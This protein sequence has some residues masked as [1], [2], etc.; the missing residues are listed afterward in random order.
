[1]RSIFSADLPD[2]T[3]TLSLPAC[4]PPMKLD[5]F[6]T[7][8]ELASE[9]QPS[10]KVGRPPGLFEQLLEGRPEVLHDDAEA[11]P[12]KYQA[13]TITL[14]QALVGGS[15]K[16]TE[17]TE[18][19]LEALD[20]ATMDFAS[21][22]AAESPKREKAQ[23]KRTPVRWVSPKAIVGEDVPPTDMPPFWWL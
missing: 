16:K 5:P 13:A 19:E 1:M 4:L 12:E 7:L 10:P 14:L 3:T 2:S 15:R 6:P 21:V 20:R 18:T 17:L 23:P 9:E 11:H 22:S 8:Y